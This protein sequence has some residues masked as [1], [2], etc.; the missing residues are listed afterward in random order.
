MVRVKI[1][2]ITNLEDAKAAIDLGA[3]A[4]GF[5]FYKRSPRYVEPTTAKPIVEAL[6]PLVSLVGIFVDEFS[7]ERILSIIHAIGIGS[8]QLHGSESPDY[9]RKISELRLIKAFRVDEKF[10]VGQLASYRV[11]AYLLDAYDPKQVGG[12]G[13]TFNWDIAIA[14]KQHGRVILAGGLGP[15][16]VYDA[17]L[18]VRPYA[19]DICSSIESEPGKKDLAK[20]ATLFRE[21]NRARV[22]LTASDGS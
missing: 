18:H 9:A 12:T 15:E 4:L 21:I 1:C 5:N 7:P 10:E 11:G 16:N 13:Q 2:G 8:V 19:V 3:D 6:P 20:M 22:A 14:A 17:I